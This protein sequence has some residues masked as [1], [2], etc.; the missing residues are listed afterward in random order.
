MILPHP[1]QLIK[2]WRVVLLMLASWVVVAFSAAP[3]DGPVLKQTLFEHSAHASEGALGHVHK[4]YKSGCDET[5]GGHCGT[6]V[7]TVM[8]MLMPL[9]VPLLLARIVPELK[10]LFARDVG[11]ELPPP[12]P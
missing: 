9:S 1:K 6:K 10:P 4:T 3:L 2:E 5:K 7:A 12:K 8:P 11:E